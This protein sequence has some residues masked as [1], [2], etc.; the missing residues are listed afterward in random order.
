MPGSWRRR[1]AIVRRLIQPRRRRLA[2]VRPGAVPGSIEPHAPEAVRPARLALVHYTAAGLV[3][4][5]VERL[6]DCFPFLGQPGVTWINIDGLGDPGVLARAGDRFGFHPL[7][8]EDVVTAPQRPKLEAYSDHAFLVLRMV[9]LAPELEEEQ[10]SLFLGANYVVTVQERAGGDVF[11]SVRERIR[12]DR[13]RIRRAGPDYLA[14]SLVD[15][16]VDGYFPVLDGLGERLEALEDEA[17]TDPLASLLAR[18]Q[19]A[20]RDLLSLRR[21][22]WPT[23]EAVLALLRDDSPLVSA[24]TRTFL[25]DCHDHTVQA[26]EIVETYR[27]TASALIE[28]Y[29]SAQNQRLNEVMKVLT[30]IATLFIPLTFIASIYGM[31]FEYMPELRW[32]WSYPSVLGVMGAVAGSLLYYFRR[33][34]WW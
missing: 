29:L 33:R 8:L 4:T 13:G 2:G 9:R 5:E 20:R 27:E 28:I 21:G 30:V 34:G 18:I 22:L 10:V 14:Y 3:E 1:Q 15:A 17:V 31:N 24:E 25:R 26:L 6:E 32:R 11:E 19:H 7:A 12:R 23:R 16:V